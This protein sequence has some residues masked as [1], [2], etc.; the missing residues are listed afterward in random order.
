M[1]EFRTGKYL[2]ALNI[3]GIHNQKYIYDVINKK[4]IKV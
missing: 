4:N 3:A 2:M 1:R